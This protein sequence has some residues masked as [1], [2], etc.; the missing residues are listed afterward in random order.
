M[1]NGKAG[2][3]RQQIETEP[4]FVEMVKWRTGAEGRIAAH[5]RQHDWDHP[6]L[7]TLQG[8]RTWCAWG[9]LAYNAT[10]FAALTH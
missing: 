4:A 3:A 5:K 10:K 7:R 2:L 1:R 8:A 9:V 6:R